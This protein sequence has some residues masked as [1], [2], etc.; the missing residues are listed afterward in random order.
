MN[1]SS[2]YAT[3]RIFG[4]VYDVGD[5]SFEGDDDEDDDEDD[6]DDDE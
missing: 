2:R 6:D 4:G 5:E 3:Q 1:T